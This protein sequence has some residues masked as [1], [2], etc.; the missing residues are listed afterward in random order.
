MKTETELEKLK[1]QVIVKLTM[2]I[3]ACRVKSISKKQI[4]QSL[5]RFIEE[6]K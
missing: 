3:G 2:L 1:T 5:E 4:E 6:L